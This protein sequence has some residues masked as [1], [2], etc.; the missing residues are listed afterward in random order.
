MVTAPTPCPCCVKNWLGLQRGGTGGGQ[1]S[2]VGTTSLVWLSEHF[3]RSSFCGLHSDPK[4]WRQ[5]GWMDFVFPG[6]G[7]P[8]VHPANEVS[9]LPYCV[10][11]KIPFSF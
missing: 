10:S 1:S 7:N 4:T 9:V 5:T 6:E 2:Q 8:V 3:L 11:A